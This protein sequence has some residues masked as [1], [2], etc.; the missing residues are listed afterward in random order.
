MK[1]YK[2]YYKRLNSEREQILEKINVLKMER[3]QPLEGREGSPYGKREE[4]ASETVEL[5]KKLVLENKMKDTLVEIEHAIE[6]YNN[7]TYGMCDVC[8]Q[9]I[10]EDRLKVQPQ[11]SLCIKCKSRPVK[12]A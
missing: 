7:G 12:N 11:A 10:D 4:E 9:E 5:E 6:K 3:Q 2:D 8:G 1:K